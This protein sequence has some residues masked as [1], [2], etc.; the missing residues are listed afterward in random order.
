MNNKFRFRTISVLLIIAGLLSIFFSVR[1]NKVHKEFVN[2]ASS[3]LAVV[4]KVDD[5]RN[6]EGNKLRRVFV[7]YEINGIEF[8]DIKLRETDSSLSKGDNVTI[9]Y[10]ENNPED[11]RR[12]Q[13]GFKRNIP[14]NILGIVMIIVGFIRF[15]YVNKIENLLLNGKK[16]YAQVISVKENDNSTIKSLIPKSHHHEIR[17]TYIVNCKYVSESN[18][19]YYFKSDPIYQDARF[20]IEGKTVPVYI[21]PRDSKDY[22]VDLN[23]LIDVSYL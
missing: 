4:T 21:N 1:S 2:S 16:V 23:S 13:E 6:A 5:Y 15:K 11:I 8:N 17:K 12:K 19:I 7:S 22:Y 14:F 3:T 10:K 9:Y 18:V 20:L